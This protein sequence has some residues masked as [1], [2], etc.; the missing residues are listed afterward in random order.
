MR[1]VLLHF[2]GLIPVQIEPKQAKSRRDD[3][4]AAKD[5]LM[6]IDVVGRDK[7]ND[8]DVVDARDLA[9]TARLAEYGEGPGV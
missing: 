2:S 6:I 3:C 8:N 9:W 7:V 1:H 5:D 4:D